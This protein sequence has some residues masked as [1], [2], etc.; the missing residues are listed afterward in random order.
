MKLHAFNKLR[1][2]KCL[3]VLVVI[4]YFHLLKVNSMLIT[5]NQFV[6]LQRMHA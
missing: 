5:S 3:C 4:C 2:V 6:F 1:A